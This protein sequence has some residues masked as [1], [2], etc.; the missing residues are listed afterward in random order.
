MRGMQ[1]LNRS[2]VVFCSSE[3]TRQPRLAQETDSWMTAWTARSHIRAADARDGH[4]TVAAGSPGL[5][6]ARDARRSEC[7]L[8]SHCR[9]SSPLSPATPG[10]WRHCSWDGVRS[11]RSRRSSGNASAPTSFAASPSRKRCSLRAATM[12]ARPSLA[13]SRMLPTKPSQTTTSASP[14]YRPSPSMY[15]LKF[16]PCAFCNRLAASLT[17]WLPLISSVPTLSRATR[18]ETQPKASAATAPIT[19]N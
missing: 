16:T 14:R 13:F 11:P 5:P 18:G 19:A 7:P 9:G 10:N 2:L 4:A 12:A 15:P 17:C 8:P 6:A 3:I 1:T